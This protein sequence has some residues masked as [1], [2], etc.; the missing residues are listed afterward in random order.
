M[1]PVWPHAAPPRWDIALSLCM[2][3][4]NTVTAGERNPSLEAQ[5][6]TRGL[7]RERRSQRNPASLFPTEPRRPD[8]LTPTTSTP[9]Q[10]AQR[11]GAETWTLEGAGQSSVRT[12]GVG[13]IVVE[14]AICR[15]CCLSFLNSAS[16][17]ADASPYHTSWLCGPPLPPAQPQTIRFLGQQIPFCQQHVRLWWTLRPAVWKRDSPMWKLG[18]LLPWRY[19]TSIWLCGVARKV[20]WRMRCRPMKTPHAWPSL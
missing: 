13:G 8:R 6:S 14:S 20:T 18:S 2:P 15:I 9:T 10:P 1:D 17:L 12:C 4:H 16:T 5:S 11:T 19:I 7:S 3:V